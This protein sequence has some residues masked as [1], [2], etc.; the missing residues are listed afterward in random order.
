VDGVTSLR[1]SIELRPT[2]DGLVVRHVVG[3]EGR[4]ARRLA[5]W[6]LTQLPIGGRAW[7][8]LAAVDGVRPDTPLPDRL[9]VLWPYT[10]IADPRLRLTSRVAEIHA[11]ERDTDRHRVKVG[12]AAV[13]GRLAYLRDGWLFEKSFEPT[14]GEHVD[15][16]AV[17]QVYADERFIEL[18]TLG[19][20][21]DVPPGG[22]VVH[23]ERWRVRRVS[24]ADARAWLAVA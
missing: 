24:E 17:A 22:E 7:L 11:V 4:D 20:L 23:V 10:D 6:A 14:P 15:F 2:S 8:P 12:S 5:P 1:R 16:G 13:T 18:E 9:L 21:V 3:N 19:P